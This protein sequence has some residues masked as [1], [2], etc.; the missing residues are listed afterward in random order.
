M[1]A[2]VS[3]AECLPHVRSLDDAGMDELRFALYDVAEAEEP[4]SDLYQSV[5]ASLKV[6]AHE[7]RR[8]EV[9]GWFG[10]AHRAAGLGGDSEAFVEA[11][12]ALV[13]ARKDLGV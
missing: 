2:E 9:L 5:L 3:H 1:A 11:L 8:R 7:Q 12:A 6:L 4:G 13:Q 10:A